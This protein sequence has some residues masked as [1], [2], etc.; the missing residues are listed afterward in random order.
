MNEENL[1]GI[2]RLT[3]AFEMTAEVG[4]EGDMG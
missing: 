2:A 3:C 4:E 1:N